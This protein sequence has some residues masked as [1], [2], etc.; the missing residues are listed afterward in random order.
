MSLTFSIQA[1]DGSYE[2]EF[3]DMQAVIDHVGEDVVNGGVSFDGV[4]AGIDPVNE[5]ARDALMKH[6]SQGDMKAYFTKKLEHALY[7]GETELARAMIKKLP[8]DIDLDNKDLI[9]AAAAGKDGPI[10]EDLLNAS[11]NID[12]TVTAS[13]LAYMAENGH[14]TAMDIVIGK[15]N[16][17]DLTKQMMLEYAASFN[18]MGLVTNLLAQGAGAYRGNE[19]PRFSSLFNAINSGNEEMA[20]AIAQSTKLSAKDVAAYISALSSGFNKLADV[21]EG[22]GLD[23]NKQSDEILKIAIN[24]NTPSLLKHLEKRGMNI[25]SK[26]DEIMEQAM[27]NGRENVVEEMANRGASLQLL[28]LD[29]IERGLAKSLEPQRIINTLERQ[30]VDTQKLQS[31]LP[32]NSRF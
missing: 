28:S 7:A 2:K 24:Y 30:G 23:V 1:V 18:Q 22:Q 20:I 6:Q 32:S 5:M 15:T 4:V 12:R 10:L 31:K 21:M 8:N 17:P 14:Q 27:I 9:L 3:K 29:A 26:R 16:S 11:P 13:T 25:E 19:V